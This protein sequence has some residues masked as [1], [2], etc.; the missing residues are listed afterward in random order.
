MSTTLLKK[1]TL[2]HVA[3]V[4]GV[5]GHDGVVLGELDDVPLLGVQIGLGVQA[6]DKVGGVAQLVKYGFAHT[7][8]NSH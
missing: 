5:D 1:E 7:G 4:A 6:L 2:E 3:A 8:H